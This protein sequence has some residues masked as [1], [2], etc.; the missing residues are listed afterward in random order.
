MPEKRYNLYNQLIQAGLIL[1]EEQNIDILLQK[2]VDIALSLSLADACSL[3]VRSDNHL[4][5]KISRNQTLE[6]RKEAYPTKQFSLEINS[7]TIAGHVAFTGEILNIPDVHSIPAEAPYKFDGR[8]DTKMNYRS[9]SMLVLPLKC[10]SGEVVGVLQMINHKAGSRVSSFP[11]GLESPLNVMANQAGVSIRNALLSEEL[12]AAQNDT[13]YRLGLAAET[14]DQETGNHLKR[15]SIYSRI[16]ADA[17]GLSKEYQEILLHAAPLH[18]V[19]K[20]GIPDSILLKNG[21][22]TEDEWS[23]MRSH[24]ELGFQILDGSQAP[25]L[26][27]GAKIALTHHEKFDGSGYPNGLA[28]HDI[29]LEGRITAIADVFDALTS[30]RSYK[31]AWDFKEV[32]EYMNSEKGRHFDG[33]LV[34]LFL[35]ELPLIL[36]VYETYKEDLGKDEDQMLQDTSNC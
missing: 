28:G 9:I 22:L 12:L 5:F 32:I 21:K 7:N 25:L 23:I 29:P 18:D 3:Y 26:K 19:G 14:R 33:E 16:L 27:M 11:A 36:E 10:S 13:V 4:K 8:F 6:A 2:V 15:M 30:R 20:I 34:D 17:A 1:S 24:P 35:N 31:N